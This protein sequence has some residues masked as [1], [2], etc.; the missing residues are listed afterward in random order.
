M[1]A[2]AQTK[3]FSKAA[4]I[5]FTSQSNVS[6]MIASLEK[7]LGK[8]VFERKQ[9]GI[10]L[11]DKGKQIYKYALSMVE[12]SAKILECAQEDATEELRVSF[13]PGSWFANA[14]CEYYIQEGAE[15]KYNVISAPAGEIVRRIIA[16]QDQ[17]GFAYFEETQLGKLKKMFQE[18]HIGYYTLKKAKTVLYCRN[19]TDHENQNEIFLVQGVEDYYLG[20]SLWK[21]QKKKDEEKRKLQVKVTTNS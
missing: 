17:L 1:V 5:L 8:K 12:C 9:H 4:S 2:C 20:I 3:S 11:T 19:K 14:F 16:S 13:Q 6:K 10:E 21:E 7:E 18:N 15:E